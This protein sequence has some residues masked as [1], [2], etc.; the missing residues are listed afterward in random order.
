MAAVRQ[1]VRIL[2][3]FC[4]FISSDPSL[5]ART[6]FCGREVCHVYFPLPFFFGLAMWH[7]G[8][9]FPIQ[10]SRN[11]THIPCIGSMGVLTT[12][13]PGKS[14]CFS[15]FLSPPAFRASI[16]APCESA[17][18]GTLRAD[19]SHNSLKA[20]PFLPFPVGRYRQRGKS[21]LEQAA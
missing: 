1:R 21:I 3:F 18:D 15:I 2:W 4:L 5:H 19:E 12:G 11:Q 9:W 13:P 14:S 20:V 6:Y 7:A 8:F 16:S 17:G 10:E